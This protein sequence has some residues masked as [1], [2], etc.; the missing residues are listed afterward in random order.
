MAQSVK[1]LSTMRE[2]RVQVLGWDD[3][4]EKEVAIHSSTIAWKIS[5]TEEPYYS[6]PM[7][8]YKGCKNSVPKAEGRVQAIFFYYLASH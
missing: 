1:R 2:T 7:A 3:S 8:N 4:L 6:Y 5:W